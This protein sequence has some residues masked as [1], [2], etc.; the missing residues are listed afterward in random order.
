MPCHWFHLLDEG[1]F[2]AFSVGQ[3]DVVASIAVPDDGANHLL[4]R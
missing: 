3:D 2:E 1:V 4:G